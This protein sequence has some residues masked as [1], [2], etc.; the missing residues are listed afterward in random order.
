MM[1]LNDYWSNINC[2][3]EFYLSD[4][5]INMD[6]LPADFTYTVFLD[7]YGTGLWLAVNKPIPE[8]A[9]M[10]LLGSG[11]VGLAGF[12]KKLKKQNWWI[13]GF[14]DFKI[15][16]EAGSRGPA[17][18][19]ISTLSNVPYR[20]DNLP[21][22]LIPWGVYGNKYISRDGWKINMGIIDIER[23]DHEDLSW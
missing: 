5:M 8:P 15:D 23:F 6:W 11:L 10:L 9:T 17:F 3:K 19:F 2:C 14:R 22:N 16:I 21:K 18:Y 4:F 13:S 1:L 20:G 12:R 7:D